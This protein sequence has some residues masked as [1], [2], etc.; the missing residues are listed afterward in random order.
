MTLGNLLNVS[1]PHFPHPNDGAKQ[2]SNIIAAAVGAGQVRVAVWWVL[3]GKVLC[4]F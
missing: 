2:P 1:G 3:A 4:P